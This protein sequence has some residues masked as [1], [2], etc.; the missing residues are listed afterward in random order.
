MIEMTPHNALDAFRDRVRWMWSQGDYTRIAPLLQPCADELADA[1]GLGEGVE[2]L[3]VAAGTG[4]FAIAA[5]ARGARVTATDLTPLMI[6][7]GSSRTKDVTPAVTWREA[8]AAVLPFADASFDVVAS[9]FGA[10][11]A[12]GF[13]RVAAE[14]FRVVKSGGPPR[15][16]H[17]GRT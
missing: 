4:N 1:V 6:E 17:V 7:L 15:P 14:M 13:D 11:F 10:M 5:A 16:V 12:P 2:V 9:V 8:D 3:D